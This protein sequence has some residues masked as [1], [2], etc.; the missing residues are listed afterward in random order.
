[1]LKLPD[2]YDYLFK[3]IIVGDTNVGKTNI[4][5]KYIKDQFNITSKSTIGVE[6]GTKILEIDNK[7]VKAQIWDT[8]GQERYKSITSAYYKGAKGA[9]IVYDITNKSTFE[10][11]DKWIKDLNSYGDKNL[12][13]LLIGN[14]SDLE[15]KRIINKEEGEEKAKSFELGFIETSA[16]NGDNIDQAFDIMLKE[17]LKRYIVE[18][19][20]NNDEFEGG[21]G[22]NIELVKKN[23]TKKKKCC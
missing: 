6:F 10:S 20:V 13:M 22:N 8:A 18:N 9:F 14:K 4:M 11:V 23:E 17:V 21:T 12:T 5:S 3:L 2:E 7:K 15:D 16:Y 19:D 1:M